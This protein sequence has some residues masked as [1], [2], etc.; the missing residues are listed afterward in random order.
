ML[1]PKTCVDF[2][3]INEMKNSQNL[4]G[5]SKSTREWFGKLDEI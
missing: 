4:Y 3:V 5:P 2:R 1:V